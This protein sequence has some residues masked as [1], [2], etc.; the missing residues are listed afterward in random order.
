MKISNWQSTEPQ[1]TLS[2]SED[3]LLK[4]WDQIHAADLAATPSDDLLAAW[5][6][7]HNGHFFDAANAALMLGSE[8]VPV[9]IRSVVAYTDYICEDEAYSEELLEQAYLLGETYSDD[10]TDN[11]YT[12]AFAMGRYSQAISITKALAKG[13]G[14]KVKKLLTAVLDAQPKHAEA[15][16][17]MAMFHAEIIDKVGGTLGGLTYGV[18]AKTA[19]NH[20]DQSLELVPNAINLIEAAN[21]ILLL[22]GDDRGMV[23]A[24][25][26]YQRAAEVE[27]LNALQAMDVD[28]AISQL[29]E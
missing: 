16:V 6:L 4:R 21:A 8:G 29:E 23:E 20:I 26:L 17:T 12:T 27:P 11:L 13:L 15:H 3:D 9:L 10:S 25:A 1:F 19:F 14:G 22:K 24:T 28:F 2:L 5:L 7:F 18:N